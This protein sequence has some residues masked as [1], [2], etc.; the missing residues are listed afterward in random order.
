MSLPQL[1]HCQT[2]KILLPYL[3]PASLPS[4]A[5]TAVTAT[6]AY[7]VANKSIKMSCATAQCEM[8]TVSTSPKIFSSV[9]PMEMGRCLSGSAGFCASPFLLGF[10]TY[11]VRYSIQAS[12]SSPFAFTTMGFALLHRNDG[13]RADLKEILNAW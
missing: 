10:R 9:L 7:G 5:G 4:G 3:T 12:G 11:T 1:R 8:R 2:A 13:P 6:V